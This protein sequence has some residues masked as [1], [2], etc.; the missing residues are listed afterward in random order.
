MNLRSIPDS[1]QQEVGHNRAHPRS[2]CNTQPAVM[3]VIKILAMLFSGL[4][5]SGAPSDICQCGQQVMDSSI[6]VNSKAL[7]P[8]PEA[9]QRHVPHLCELAPAQLRCQ[10]VLTVQ[11]ES[12]QRAHGE[13]AART[14]R[15]GSARPAPVAHRERLP[16]R[17]PAPLQG[18]TECSMHIKGLLRWQTWGSCSA[19]AVW[20]CRAGLLQA[21]LQSSGL[22]REILHFCR[23]CVFTDDHHP[24]YL[25]CWASCQRFQCCRS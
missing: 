1:L 9:A 18:C 11:I 15:A 10:M 7:H 22:G 16:R 6:A 14:W 19:K 25:A 12:W 20:W 24:E 8:S 2:T 23:L 17:P 3:H 4:C 13:L 5:A 21:S